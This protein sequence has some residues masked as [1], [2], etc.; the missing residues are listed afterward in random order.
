MPTMPKKKRATLA[1]ALALALALG[2]TGCMDPDAPG[3]LVPA[4]VEEDPSLPRI[5]V[6]GTLLHAEAFGDPR[7]PMIMMLHG[8]PGGDYRA[9]L[10][11]RVLAD[12]GYYVV[13]WDHRGSGLSKRH[14][15]S[16]GYNDLYLEDLRQV[17][18]HFSSSSTQPIAFVGHSWG[19]MYATWFINEHG[20]Y[21]GRVAGAVLSEP[22]A[23]TSSGLEDY[24]ARLLPPWS[25]TSEEL[26]DVVWSDQFMSPGDHARADFLS[27][28]RV[29]PG[30]PKEHNDPGN[31]APFWRKGAVVNA[32]I[33]E[34]AL[35]RGFDWTTRLRA[36]PRKVLFL[37]GELNENMPLW[38]QQELASHYAS[39]EVITV[40][41]AGHEA[42]WERQPEFLARIRAYFAEI[43]FA[44]MAG[45]GGAR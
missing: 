2:A 42:M 9:L 24:L 12:D 45:I 23:F 29:L 18:E 31:P 39:S 10:P 3:N 15:R 26:N 5:E 38:H 37:R 19:A 13:F 8:G 43:G 27:A 30:S 7:A 33:V 41:G 28:I 16:T 6:N 44:P 32:R 4:T 1:A 17:I 11:Y 36:F 20:D 34:D 21:G 14:S 35:D 40:L 25:Y 22:G